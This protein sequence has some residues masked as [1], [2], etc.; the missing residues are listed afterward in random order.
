[1]VATFL[2]YLPVWHAGFIWDDDA[3]VTENATL[4]SLAGLWQ[5]WFN[6]N[7][8][9]QYYPLV[10][11]TYWLEYHLWGLQPLGYHLDNVLLH[12]LAAILL[13]CVLK[14]LQL[15]GAWLAAAIFAV[16]PV[17]V[18]SVAWVTERKNVLSAVFY[19]AA[20]LAYLRFHP[21]GEVEVSRQRR[22][23][24]Y[25]WSLALFAAA[26]LS[27]TVTC[28]LPAALL[29]ARW[30]KKRRLAARDILPLLPLFVV[31]A[32]L[33]L[34][35]AWLEKY[36]VGAQ[37]PDWSLTIA[38]RCLLAG[39]ALW[40]YAGKLAW[41]APLIFIYPRW[42]INSGLWWQ[43]IFP[44]A[45]V[46]VMAGLWWLRDRIGRGPLVGVLF[47]AGTLGP[48]LGFINL[49]PMRYSL[50]SDHFV[51]LSSLGL[52]ALITALVVRTAE[53]LR[54]QELV[55]GFAVVVLPVLGILTWRQCGMYTNLETLWR[56]TIARN[57]NCWMAQSNLGN[58]LLDRGKQAEAEMHYHEALRL[59][60]D[61]TDALN[62]LAWLLATC[63]D[64]SVRNGAR[65]VPLAEH[66]C[67]L[68]EYK[69]TIYVGTLAAAYAEAG[70]FDDAIATAEKAVRL[71]EQ[72]HELELLQKNR[73]L[74]ELY[75]AHRAYHET[76]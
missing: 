61:F 14:R 64:A 71:A 41:P 21:P 3:Y 2:V 68:T 35:T 49:Y 47:F 52:I 50:V 17:Q 37:G 33:G 74:L 8:L 46:G 1:V 13:G 44:A 56:T 67:V 53:R 6:V 76:G 18:E 15:P 24:F 23:H 10:H 9:P 75:R 29:L 42:Q 25:F 73:E 39:R 40:F 65:A 7:A 62:N 55:Y 43:W 36:H 60:P 28:S 66:A 70:R 45:A 12:A 22:W 30:W 51:Y 69:Q 11:T 34:L 57:P 63:P 19:F 26:L 54:M 59:N 31:G 38:D 32:A 27:K 20:A 48:A 58:W 72:N 16:H 4:R 5:M